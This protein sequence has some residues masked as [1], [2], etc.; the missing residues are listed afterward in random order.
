MVEG[1]SG[2]SHLDRHARSSRRSV[3]SVPY[4]SSEPLEIKLYRRTT[5]A[6]SWLRTI[7]CLRE[8]SLVGLCLA[9]GMFPNTPEFAPECAAKSRPGTST[10]Q[11]LSRQQPQVTGAPRRSCAPCLGVAGFGPIKTRES[12]RSDAATLNDQ[13]PGPRAGAWPGV[14]VAPMVAGAIAGRPRGGRPNSMPRTASHR[15]RRT[16]GSQGRHSS[17]IHRLRDE[18]QLLRAG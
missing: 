3:P 8:S 15:S 13:G 6:F 10:A 11:D 1:S 14:T 9:R 4:F 7:S 16:E 18:D 2:P 12:M 5:G 17:R